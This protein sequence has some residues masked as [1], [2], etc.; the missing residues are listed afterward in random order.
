MQHILHDDTVRVQEGVVV[1]SPVGQS[2]G[3]GTGSTVQGVPD[4]GLFAGGACF[5]GEEA[6]GGTLVVQDGCFDQIERD[7]VEE[8]SCDATPFAKRAMVLL[9]PTTLVERTGKSSVIK[10][11]MEA[12]QVVMLHVMTMYAASAALCPKHNLYSHHYS[13]YTENAVFESMYLDAP[14]HFE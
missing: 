8:N 5:D 12:G 9:H 6:S 2:Q 1:Y 14:T 4:L 11:N 13:T 3:P 7:G 10:C